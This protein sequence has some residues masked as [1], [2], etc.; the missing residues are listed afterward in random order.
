M[1]ANLAVAA[2]VEARDGRWM[3]IEV[4]L[5]GETAIDEAAR[6]LLALRNKLSEEQRSR[7]AALVVV[8]AGKV[9]MSRPDGVHVVPLGVLGP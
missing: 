6:N 8:T 2:I 3:G 5:G 4:K 1:S 9:A 7:L